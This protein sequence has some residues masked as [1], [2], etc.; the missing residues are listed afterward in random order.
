MVSLEKE[1]N[2]L[3]KSSVEHDGETTVHTQEV[4]G[5]A[6]YEE[7]SIVQI[8]FA[9]FAE[10]EEHVNSQVTFFLEEDSVTMQRIGDSVMEQKFEKGKRHRG[11]YQTAYGKFAT[12]AETEKLVFVEEVDKCTLELSYHYF[13][14]DVKTGLVTIDLVLE[15]PVI[16]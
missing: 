4:T 7:G 2:I 10:H 13:V 5:I 1:L 12:A 15:I 11:L 9:D 6:Y 16:H 14:S 3:F 8:E